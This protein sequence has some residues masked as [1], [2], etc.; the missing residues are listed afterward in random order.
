MRGRGSDKNRCWKEEAKLGFFKH[1]YVG[2]L[3]GGVGNVKKC[4]RDPLIQLKLKHPLTANTWGCLK[5]RFL[6]F[7]GFR[8]SV[9]EFGSHGDDACAGNMSRSGA[10]RG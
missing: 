5:A 7:Q 3:L 10:T 1:D 4:F 8:D 2:M 9:S 6:S